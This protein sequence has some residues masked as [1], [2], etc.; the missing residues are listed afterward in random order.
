MVLAVVSSWAIS[1][2]VWGL[3]LGVGLELGEGMETDF[4]FGGG[5]EVL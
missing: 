5:V 4:V 3:V 2:C 1:N